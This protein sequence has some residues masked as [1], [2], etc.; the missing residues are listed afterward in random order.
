MLVTS[1]Y[2]LYNRPEKFIEYLYLFYDLGISGLPIT[3]FVDPSMVYKFRIFPSTVTV[4]GLPLADCEL[5]TIAMNYTGE[6]PV[7]RTPQKD[8]KEFF[9][10]MNTKM[11]FVKK[12]A[13]LHPDTDTFMWIDF[14]IM[15]IVKQSGK[16]IDMLRK[17]NDMTFQKMTIPGCWTEGRTFSVEQIHWRFC[18]GFFILPRHHVERFFQHSRCVLSDFC[19]QPQYK[20]TWE[21]NVWVVIESCAEKE[22]IDWYF[23]DHN[24]TIVLNITMILPTIMQ[25]QP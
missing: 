13:A 2:D 5:Y 17:I 4:V 22:N 24:D 18:G 25:Q 21:T 23:A 15:K 8:T 10:L 7:H 3:L 19:T 14:G 9:A 6:L 16:F 11:E 1:Y 20:L 12:A